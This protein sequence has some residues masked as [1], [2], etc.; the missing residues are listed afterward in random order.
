MFTQ[1]KFQKPYSVIRP[2]FSAD[3][4]PEKN[5]QR[6]RNLM[7]NKSPIKKK[8]LFATG[9]TGFVGQW[10]RK[11][12]QLPEIAEHVEWATPETKS[13]IR[14]V[15]QLTRQLAEV[16]PD[17]IIHLAGQSA[18]PYSFENPKETFEVNCLGT[19]NLLEAIKA[20][21]F[22]GRMLYVGSADT[23]GMVPASELPV[24]EDRPLAPRNPYASSKAAAELVC[25]Q[26]HLTDNI[27]VVLAR[28]FNH[29]G[30]GQ[31]SRF[32]IA[33]FVE[34][35]IPIAKGIAEPVVTVGDIDT[36]R[37]FSDVRDVVS[38]YLA[39]L[40]HGEAGETYNVCSGVERR[41]GDMFE[42]L[43]RISGLDVKMNVDTD[44]QRRAEQR[45]MCGDNKKCRSQ[46]GWSP[47]YSIEQTLRDVYLDALNKTE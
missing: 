19:L 28:P 43:I 9:S 44:K 30:P 23:Y 40:E 45:R 5:W 35:L 34:Q 2:N 11:H 27:D 36:T 3:Q 20:S 22:S 16:R 8:R 47:K 4:S 25:R 26:W 12:I 24:S 18:V 37:D 13:D 39:L 41:V 14:D 6:Q 42:G 21:G 38:A 17:W 10:L 1:V 7:N 32:A 15:Q 46:T 33:S 31:S 29:I